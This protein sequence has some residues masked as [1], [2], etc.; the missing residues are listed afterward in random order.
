MSF[1][2]IAHNRVA[3]DREVDRCN[4]ATVPLPDEVIQEARRGNLGLSLTGGRMVP[5]CWLG[6]LSTKRVLCLACSGGQQV[7]LLAAAGANVTALDNSP[8]QVSRD[9]E[10]AERN[11][12]PV[13]V[14]VGDMQ[15]LSRFESSSFEIAFLGLGLQ[16]IPE[17]KRVWSG[18]A[19]VLEPGGHVIAGILNPVQY[20]FEWPQYSNGIFCARHSLPYSDLDSL[21]EV[22]R[23]QR[24]DPHDPIE[25]GHTM[26]DLLGSMV[27]QGFA[28]TGFL[29]DRI[30]DDPLAKLIATCFLIRAE[31]AR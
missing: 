30:D 26:E 22:Q 29:E 21:D 25:F 17:P 14:E 1:D 19:K 8:R 11:A 31:L 28:V 4:P 16:F 9:M 20:L 12:L 10:V 3:W 13:R 23:L 15:D 5:S 6:Q 27:D 18:L 2:V 7:P 24:F